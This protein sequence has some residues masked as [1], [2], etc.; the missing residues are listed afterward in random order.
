M[1][2]GVES[3]VSERFHDAT[4]SAERSDD[5]TV[6]K[7]RVAITVLRNC[8]TTAALDWVFE[9]QQIQKGCFCVVLICEACTCTTKK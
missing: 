8:Y 6:F 9:M 1:T 2:S 3:I 5:S 7:P 4:V